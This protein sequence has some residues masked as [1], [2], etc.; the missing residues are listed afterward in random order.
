MVHWSSVEKWGQGWEIGRGYEEYQD[1]VQGKR[2]GPDY[3][4]WGPEDMDGAVGIQKYAGRVKAF[5]PYNRVKVDINSTWVKL[6]V[7]PRLA[8]LVTVRIM[9]WIKDVSMMGNYREV[10]ICG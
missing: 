2:R 3:C 6:I 10:K 7:V 9:F 8:D 4:S 5:L 1:K